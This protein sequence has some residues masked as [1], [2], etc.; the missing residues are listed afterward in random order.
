[1]ATLKLDPQRLAQFPKYRR[2]RQQ[3]VPLY[4]LNI[5]QP[6]IQE[7]NN[8]E[9]SSKNDTKKKLEKASKEIEVEYIST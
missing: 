5:P 8:S 3:N 2:K 6:I 1:L 4:Q 9:N 7:E